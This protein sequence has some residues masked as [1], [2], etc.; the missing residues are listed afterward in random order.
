MD[1]SDL[2]TLIQ[3][4]STKKVPDASNMC[5]GIVVSEN[6]ADISGNLLRGCVLT[7][8]EHG[9]L[10]ENIHIK[11]HI[12]TVPSAFQLVYGANQMTLTGNYDAVILLGCIIRGETSQFD[13]LG[14]GIYDGISHL[15]TFKETPIVC[16]V[17]TTETMEQA[18]ARSEH[19]PL[20]RGAESA[21]EAIKMA[22]F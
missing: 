7:L 3:Q 22:K 1:L 12:K 21:V 16:G 5:F 18:I 4:L 13:L 20:N 14:H 15:M 2:S 8:E 17:L 11:T 6:K 9:A 10:P 19:G